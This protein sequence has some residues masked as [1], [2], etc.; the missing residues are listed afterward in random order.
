MLRYAI[1]SN[2]IMAMAICIQLE[3]IQAGTFPQETPTRVVFSPCLHCHNFE[4]VEPDVRLR[5]VHSQHFIR[6]V[7]HYGTMFLDDVPASTLRL[8]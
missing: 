5:Q 2:A 7:H 3:A 8:W 4:Q 6:K 1:N